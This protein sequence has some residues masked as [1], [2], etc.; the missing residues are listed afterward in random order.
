MKAIGYTKAGPITADDALI[1]FDAP[2]PDGGEN[3]LLVEVRAISVNPVDTK[4][5]KNKAPESGTK[6]IGYDAAGGGK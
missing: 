5:R 2:E 6:I 1:E 3:D 4:V